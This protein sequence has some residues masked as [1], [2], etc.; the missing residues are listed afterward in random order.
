MQSL[1]LY[2]VDPH[3]DTVVRA[4]VSP[5]NTRGTSDIL[6]TCIVTI[7]L[8][9]YTAVHL[10]IPPPGERFYWQW[11]RRAKWTAFGIFAPEIVLFTALQQFQEARGLA[12]FLNREE[13]KQHSDTRPP[14]RSPLYLSMLDWCSDMYITLFP[15]STGAISKK[16]SGSFDLRYGFFVQMGGLRANVESLIHEHESMCLEA[17]VLKH[18]ARRGAFFHIDQRSIDDRSKADSFAKLVVCVQVSWMLVQSVTRAFSSYS[19]TLLEIHTFVHVVCAI[20]M[21]GLWFK[22]RPSTTV[23]TLTADS[24]LETI[25]GR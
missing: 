13:E 12:A 1:T 6:Y 7:V 20:G 16:K 4:W 21:Y 8:C 11:L 23:A 9:V 24:S 3:N 22:V 14:Q 5:P 19:L 25:R 2:D 17:S 15:D 18:L 10:N